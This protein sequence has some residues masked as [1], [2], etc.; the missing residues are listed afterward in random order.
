MR[1]YTGVRRRCFGLIKDW[2]RLFTLGRLLCSSDLCFSSLRRF[3]PLLVN[4]AGS[5]AFFCE[6]KINRERRTEV[7]HGFAVAV[8]VVTVKLCLDLPHVLERNISAKT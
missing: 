4:L 6:K 3:P 5:V 1:D 8:A 7:S 2:W